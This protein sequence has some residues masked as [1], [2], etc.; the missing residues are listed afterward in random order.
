MG[1]RSLI[2]ITVALAAR[3]AQAVEID[4]S[5]PVTF[6]SKG[7]PILADG[8]WYSGDPA[9]LVVN[10][11]V[12]ILSGKDDAPPDTNSFVM[13]QWGM[14]ES[15][16]PDPAGSE[17]TLYPN[18]AAPSE[19]F[20]WA[21]EGTAYAAQV[22]QG[23][24]QK[25]YLYAPVTEANSPN[26]DPFAIGV[27]VSD[28]PTGPYEDAHPDGPIVSQSVPTG[29]D[30]QNI[31]PTVIVDDDGSVYLYFGTF[32]RLLG[33]QLDTDMTTITGDVIEV[34]TSTLTGY[35]EAPWLMKRK[36]TYYMV[37]A[38]NNAGEDSPCTPTSYH[39]CIAY[40]SSSSPLGPWT[41]QGVVLHI[42]SS[43]TSHPG[44]VESN[45]SWYLV[46]HTADAEGGYHFRRSVAFDELTWDDS[47]SPPT[48]NTVKQTFAPQGD[49]EPTRNIAGA[50]NASSENTTPIQYWV[51]ALHDGVISANP[52]PPD[53]WSSYDG[54]NSP[55]EST[56]VYAW[57]SAVTLDGTAMVFFADQPA[58]ASEGVAPPTAWH[59]EYLE[60][61]SWKEVSNSSPYPLEVSDTPVE[62]GF[63]EIET[64]SIR[65]V[66]SA[67]GGSGG[68]AGVG[69]KEWY[70]YA[71]TAQ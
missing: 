50:A 66:L 70:A 64:T 44:V 56:V 25:F 67:S 31:D 49:A 8:S 24:D 51:E 68:Y 36:D 22:V 6:T 40:A 15:A 45:G 21:S 5:D 43:T 7:N 10:N 28:S 26:T 30:I 61:G 1:M 48:I 37:Y 23:P 32:G 53:I 57:D 69:I 60:N 34:D 19:V 11:T 38:A 63:D 17:W 41:F 18:I 71:P 4:G 3:I 9:P 39:A 46:Y 35:F 33:Y 52:L 59:V 13:P 29:N 14:F 20:S 27:A 16:S 58:G 62:V 47:Q 12:Y 65:A 42:V 55:A 2:G 54:T